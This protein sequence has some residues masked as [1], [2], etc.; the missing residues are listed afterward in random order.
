MNPLLYKKSNFLKGCKLRRGQ[1]ILELPLDHQQVAVVE[2]TVKWLDRLLFT[3]RI[4]LEQESVELLQNIRVLHEHLHQLLFVS[5]G[6]LLEGDRCLVL[7]KAA[8]GDRY[9]AA[10]PIEYL[11]LYGFYAICEDLLELECGLYD[12][13]FGL[14]SDLFGAIEGRGKTALHGEVRIR[15]RLLALVQLLHALFWL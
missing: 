4:L 14:Q 6:Q 15:E 7:H 8:V 12:V 11:L 9:S 3:T 2:F 1:S 13:D 10:G 5:Q